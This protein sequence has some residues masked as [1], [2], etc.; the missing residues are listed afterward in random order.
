MRG[1]KDVLEHV[2]ITVQRFVELFVEA[3]ARV[4]AWID[5]HKAYL[6]LMAA[7]AAGAVALSAALNPVG[8]CGAGEAGLRRFCGAVCGWAGGRKREGG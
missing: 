5:E 1:A 4:L 7:V 2:K 6:F 3:V 8:S